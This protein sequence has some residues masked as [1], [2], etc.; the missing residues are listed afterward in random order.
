MIID[1][2]WGVMW[3][4]LKFIFYYLLDVYLTLIVVLYLEYKYPAAASLIKSKLFAHAET[5]A[6]KVGDDVYTL[7]GKYHL[8]NV[9]PKFN[10][11]R[12]EDATNRI[13]IH[14]NLITLRITDPKVLS[15][16]LDT[17][18][19]GN[20]MLPIIFDKT[21]VD[22]SHKLVHVIG[23]KEHPITYS[24]G[25]PFKVTSGK[26]VLKKKVRKGLGTHLQHVS[27]D[28]QWP[29]APRDISTKEIPE[30]KED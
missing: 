8:D 5:L 4:L 17:D 9:I 28:T 27:E 1:A 2:L 30:I 23:D 18:P 6:L 25:V 21:Y 29:F 19:Q 14:W 3:W 26:L 12:L 16:A 10:V 13:D 20:V 7:K 15:D 24:D 22:P 11:L